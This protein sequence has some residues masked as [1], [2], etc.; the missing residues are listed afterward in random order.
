MI[1]A[2]NTSTIQYSVGILQEDGTILCEYTMDPKPGYFGALMP[3]L[4]KLMKSANIGLNHIKSIVITIGPGSFTGLRIGLAVA[5]GFS[6]SR[7]IP[8]IG[9]SSLKALAYQV[10][11]FDLPVCSVISSKKGELFAGLFTV[12]NRD[13]IDIKGLKDEM[14]IKLK[15]LPEYVSERCIFIGSDYGRQFRELKGVMGDNALFAPPHLWSIR[16]SSVGMVGLKR[17]RNGD[18]DE[19]D[20]LV[21][22]YLKSPDIRT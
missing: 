17:Y 7:D 20:T 1:L 4:D 9:V 8:L 5:K 16:A 3:S 13:V 14:S 19:P 11:S 10:I 21:P 18:F 22:I 2:I 12:E 6:H 15:D